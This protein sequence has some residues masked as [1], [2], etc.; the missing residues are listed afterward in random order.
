MPGDEELTPE[1]LEELRFRLVQLQHEVEANLAGLQEEAKPVDLELS[2]GRLSRVDAMQQQQMA[3]A[4]MQRLQDQLQQI[5][6]AL[7]RVRSGTYG[8]CLKCEEPI[9]A[10]RLRARPEALVCRACGR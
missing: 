5:R 2:I 9:G 7:A 6:S 3:T 4:R 1:V 8:D 10:Q